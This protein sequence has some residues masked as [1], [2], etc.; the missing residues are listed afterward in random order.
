[1]KIFISWSGERS[2][3][4]AEGLNSWL[5][6]VIQAVKPFY[7]PEIEKGTKGIEE[8]NKTL[9]GTSFGIICLTPDNIQ[10][11]WIHYEAGALSK[12]EGARIWTLLYNLN[13]SDIV[14]PLAQFQHTLTKKDDIYKLLDSI[15]VKLSEPLEKNVLKDSFE[16]WWSDCEEILTNA[17]KAIDGKQ[18][19]D[20][21]EIENIRSDREILDE[22]LEIL[23]GQQRV[24]E[25]ETSQSKSRQ[26]KERIKSNIEKN[27][28]SLRK[29]Q[30]A[31]E[32]QKEHRRDLEAKLLSDCD[33]DF[34]KRV[35]SWLIECNHKI[36]DIEDS[37]TRIESWIKEGTDK[38]NKDYQH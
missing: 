22:M 7:S 1:M 8:I 5:P 23:R 38:L 34:R 11:T 4:I 30:E 14:Q 12:I 16:R 18:V 13:P 20:S 35:S 29:A 9:E 2:R 26:S 28:E 33:E 27:K 17:N 21:K 31:L 37:I 3:I 19:K 36:V 25:V 6:K 10:S 32:R 24:L 15:N